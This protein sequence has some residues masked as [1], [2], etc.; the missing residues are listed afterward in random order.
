MKIKKIALALFAGLVSFI[1]VNATEQYDSIVGVIKNKYIPDSRVA[2]W[3]VKTHKGNDGVLVLKGKT[4]NKEARAELLSEMKNN[5]IE[6]KDS[7]QLL[8]EASLDTKW[9]L[10]SISVACMR[11]TAASS[12][13]LIS[14]TILGT[15]VKVLERGGDMS[16]IQTPDNYL[17]YI[18][19][20]SLTFITTSEMEAW[21][22]SKR[23]VVTQREIN[24]YSEPNEDDMK[25]VSDLLLGNIVIYK[26]AKKKFY[27]IALPDGRE[28]FVKKSNVEFLDEWA[29]QKFS[30]KLLEKN[31]I[32]MMG[33]P[34]LWGG[35]SSKT[36]DCSGFVK[37]LYFSNGII[38]Q[39]D[40]SQQALTGE[41]INPNNWKTDAKKG[42]LIFIGTKTGKVTHVAM[43]LENGKYIHS[44]GR[45]K[46]NSMDKESED[47]HVYNY[48]S[49]SRINGQVG[50]K[51][52][53][54]VKSHPW[55]F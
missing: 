1:S 28:G 26:D 22:A 49:M 43:Y 44:S 31:A 7:I 30:D 51:G 11:K 16:L 34:Y 52:I 14:Q 21:K 40:A 27:K 53:V 15:P 54:A 48:L 45:V 32:K 29:K 38:L 10:I 6:Y 24:V 4:D 9:G 50:T 55:Y 20:N 2:L 3:T 23:L 19:N 36:M 18:T 46:V 5:G 39:R 41:K 33:R 8:P 17:G 13:E 12:S 37:T 47:Y 25:I 35:M 42:D